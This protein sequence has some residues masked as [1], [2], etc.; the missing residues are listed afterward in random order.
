M[1]HFDNWITS[2]QQATENH[3]TLPPAA[4]CIPQTPRN[5]RFGG[6]RVWFLVILGRASSLIT[7]HFDN[8]IIKDALEIQDYLI[9]SA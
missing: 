2:L 7:G 4:G 3:L 1:R 8:W 9:H 6:H 5:G